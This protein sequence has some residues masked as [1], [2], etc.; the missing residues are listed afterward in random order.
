MSVLTIYICYTVY[1]GLECNKNIRV[2]ILYYIR[3]YVVVVK[4]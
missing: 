1:N 4:R 2:C 3:T